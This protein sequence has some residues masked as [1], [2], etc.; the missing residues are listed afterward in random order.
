M[1]FKEGGGGGF[2]GTIES[3][4]FESKQ[5]EDNASL[6]A[7][8]TITRDGADEPFR[9]MLP[10]G[11]LFDDSGITVNDDGTLTIEDGKG[12]YGKSEFANFVKSAWAAGREVADFGPNEDDYSALAGYR[13]RFV[14]W[15]DEEK[16]AKKGKR[17]GSDGKSYSWSEFRVE[18][19]HGPV[20]ATKGK[21][22]AAKSTV[23]GNG[24]VKPKVGG[25]PVVAATDASD[26]AA[27]N[28]VLLD[29][30]TGYGKDG[31]LNR[32]A[33]NQSV[34][35]YSIKKKMS[36]EERDSLREQLV[37]EDVLSRVAELGVIAYNPKGGDPK[38]KG[39]IAVA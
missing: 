31:M 1:G 19:V 17:K 30:I 20:T 38:Q 11:T 5:W 29:L 24:A 9:K 36:E 10:A 2:D 21:A 13:Y 23:K 14:N 26:D 4:E 37:D 27:L 15:I 3:V 34:V 22:T 25:K 8:V 28:T 35:R 18:T 39:V 32:A 7:W 12:L 16:T 6:T 33:I